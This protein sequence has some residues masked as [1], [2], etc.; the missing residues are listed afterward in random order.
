MKELMED[1]AKTP[2]TTENKRKYIYLY[3]KYFLID[4]ISEQ[5]KAFKSGFTRVCAGKIL[6]REEREREREREITFDHPVLCFRTCCIL[7]S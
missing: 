2:V 6:V 7:G 5:F 4:S 1:G 3:M